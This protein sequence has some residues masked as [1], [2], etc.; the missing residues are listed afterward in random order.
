VLNCNRKRSL[1]SISRIRPAS[2]VLGLLADSDVFLITPER[3]LARVVD[4]ASRLRPRLVR[5]FVTGYGPDGPLAAEPTFDTVLQGR[6][7]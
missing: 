2:R 1:F 3:G 5:C 7:R 4:G 6:V